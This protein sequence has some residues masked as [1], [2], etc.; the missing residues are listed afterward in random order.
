MLSTPFLLGMA[1]DCFYFWCLWEIWPAGRSVPADGLNYPQRGWTW[2]LHPL[3]GGFLWFYLAFLLAGAEIIAH[4]T[5]CQQWCCQTLCLKSKK[6]WG[7]VQWGNMAGG[8]SCPWALTVLI[9]KDT[10]KVVDNLSGSLM[11][12]RV[13]QNLF[14]FF[15]GKVICMHVCLVFLF[16]ALGFIQLLI[17]FFLVVTTL[18]LIQVKIF[19]IFPRQPHHSLRMWRAPVCCNDCFNFS[20][21]NAL[22]TG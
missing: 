4:T 22:Q 9:S 3:M 18:M 7:V 13:N 14:D 5:L 1:G 8:R 2:V 12:C 10:F 17:F 15:P 6:L 20:K 19:V 21:Q 11:R 16:L